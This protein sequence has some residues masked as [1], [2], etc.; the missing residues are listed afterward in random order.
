MISS[1][2]KF[3]TLPIA[4]S[5]KLHPT[6]AQSKRLVHPL[7]QATVWVK[8]KMVECPQVEKSSQWTEKWDLPA[9]APPVSVHQ[10]WQPRKLFVERQ[11]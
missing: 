4:R 2:H 3:N 1:V 11:P 7:N 6:F 10:F 5:S 9:V 8:A